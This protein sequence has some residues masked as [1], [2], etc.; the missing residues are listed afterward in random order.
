MTLEVPEVQALDPGIYPANVTGLEVKTLDDGT[1]FRIWSFAIKDELGT[2]V[3]ASSSMAFGSKSKTYKWVTALIGR[4]PIPGEKLEVVGL[5]CQLHL[6]V[7][8][9]SGYNRVEAVLPSGVPVRSASPTTTSAASP[10]AAAKGD[11][12]DPNWLPPLEEPPM[13]G[14]GDIPG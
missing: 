2:K 5:S 10:S 4:T 7:D 9:D 11:P 8:E 14:E 3:T 6:I 13:V 12:N 1:S